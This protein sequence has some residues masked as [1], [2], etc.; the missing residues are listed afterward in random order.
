MSKKPKGETYIPAKPCPLGHLSPRT[1]KNR[2][3]LECASLRAKQWYVR[4]PEK[5]KKYFREWRRNNFA[6]KHGMSNAHYDLIYASQDGKCAICGDSSPRRGKD[7]LVIDHCHATGGVRGLLCSR[8]N[9]A[10]G[11]L[12]DEPRLAELAADYLRTRAWK[13]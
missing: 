3:C 7:R 2:T 4:N 5:A 1:V 10:I 12:R 13:N 9:L 8:C 11:H 6:V